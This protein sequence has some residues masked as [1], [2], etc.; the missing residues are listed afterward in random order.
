MTPRRTPTSADGPSDDST[1]RLAL[2]FHG[3]GT[4]GRPLEPGEAPCWLPV[5]KFAEML[6]EVAG[7][8]DVLITFDDGNESDLTVAAPL[9]RERGLTAKFFVIAA[10][11][12]TAGSLSAGDLREL[13]AQGMSVGT[14]GYAHRPWR[15]LDA[16][17][18]RRELVEAREQ[19]A[20]AAGRPVVDAACPFGAYDRGSLGALRAAGYRTVY[21]VDG[22][23]PEPGAWLQTRRSIHADDDPGTVRRLV[24]ES[25]A[26]RRRDPIRTAKLFVKRWR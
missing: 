4:P 12:G 21:T 22:G 1:V 2:C 13:V 3:V 8:P 25:R 10:R 11:I 9:L 19:I 15:K 16:G 26:P 5:E 7:A 6:D 17:T 14:H 24:R 23:F 18:S 20:D